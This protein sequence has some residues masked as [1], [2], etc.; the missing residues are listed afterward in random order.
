MNINSTSPTKPGGAP[1]PTS[2][3]TDSMYTNLKEINK[4]PITLTE[5]EKISR[6]FE[7]IFQLTLDTKYSNANYKCILIGE[8]MNTMDS[9]T[10]LMKENLDEVNLHFFLDINIIS[11]V[12]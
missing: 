11:F 1:D 12:Y 5:N 8:L 3:P 9:D 2:S 4:P 10:L 6:L 7:R